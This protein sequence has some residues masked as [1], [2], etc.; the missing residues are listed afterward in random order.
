[1]VSG[2]FPKLSSQVHMNAV[3]YRNID[4]NVTESPAVRSKKFPRRNVLESRPS[5][6]RFSLPSPPHSHWTWE[7]YH[8]DM[9]PSLSVI[10]L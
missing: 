4:L 9:L 10:T 1:M 7:V 2:K 6:S 8:I 5:L 3:D